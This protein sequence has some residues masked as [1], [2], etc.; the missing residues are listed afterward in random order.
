MRKFFAIFAWLEIILGLA[1]LWMTFDV[2][3]RATGPFRRLNRL[4]WHRIA[5]WLI[6]LCA[7][8]VVY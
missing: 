2:G 3:L 1:M 6:D 4:N 5:I 8:R 7:C